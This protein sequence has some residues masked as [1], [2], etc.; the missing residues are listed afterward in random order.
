MPQGLKTPPYVTARPEVV[1]HA[2]QPSD[3]FVIL[4]SDGLW[5]VVGNKTAVT[6]AARALQTRGDK[7][8]ATEGAAVALLM[9]ALQGY[10]SKYTKEGDIGKLLEMS[11]ARDYRD[12]I[13]ATVVVLQQ[14]TRVA[15]AN[16]GKPRDYNVHK[17]LEQ[18]LAAVYEAS[19]RK[20][21]VS[22]SSSSGDAAQK[23]TVAGG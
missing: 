19:K 9:T 3:R 12:D 20:V 18:T 22:S 13:T 2:R 1:Y 5:D 6:V 16:F 8:K 10:A 17:P 15:A 14:D 7:K 4:A 21:V 11:Y 23:K